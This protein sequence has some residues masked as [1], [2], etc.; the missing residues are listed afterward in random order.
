MTNTHILKKIPIGLYQE[1]RDAPKRNTTAKGKAENGE[2]AE[3][4]REEMIRAV[5]AA[6]LRATKQATKP[7]YL[8]M[9]RLAIIRVPAG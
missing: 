3:E 1:T 8:M 4:C 5:K 9:T 6:M 2:K 7:I